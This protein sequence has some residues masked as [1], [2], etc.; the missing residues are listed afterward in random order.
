MKYP[1]RVRNIKF[2]VK[3]VR[4]AHLT[5]ITSEVSELEEISAL[6][7]TLTEGSQEAVI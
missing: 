5:L 1:I 6:L 4:N 7:L 3:P 2:H